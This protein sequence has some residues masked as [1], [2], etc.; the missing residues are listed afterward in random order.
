MNFNELDKEMRVFETK[1]ERSFFKEDYL[2]I[3]LDGRGFSR[4][5]ERLELQK[6]FDTTFKR[7]M[8]TVTEHLM[9]TNKM[10]FKFLYGY[11]Q[12][13]EISLLLSASDNNYER[14]ERKLISTLAS[15]AG[16]VFTRELSRMGI[17]EVA[18]FDARVSVLPTYGRIIDYFRWRQEDATRNALS[19][20]AY[21][22]LRFNGYNGTQAARVL[23]GMSRAGKN[24]LLFK[25]GINFNDVLPWHKRGTGFYTGNVER[26]GHNPVTNKDVVVTRRQLIRDDNLP[27]GDEY[28][29][30]LV[31]LLLKD[32]DATESN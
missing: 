6:P 31:E 15:A 14:K 9:T 24:E 25:Y 30:F 1:N 12:S 28:A 3:R 11:H 16:A 17:D 7:I 8:D 2:V 18:I 32:A 5:T 29:E 27:Y 13:D 22:T 21:W 20:Y 4:L 19:G 26:I 10:G 23:Q